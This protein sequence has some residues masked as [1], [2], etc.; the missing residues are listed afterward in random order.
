M[1]QKVR[2]IRDYTFRISNSV[3]KAYRRGYEGL[4]PDAHY[5]AAK[6]AGALEEPA[7]IVKAENKT[8][9]KD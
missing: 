8:K 6:A 5:E 3:E 1:A 7:P 2:F 9:P 4:I